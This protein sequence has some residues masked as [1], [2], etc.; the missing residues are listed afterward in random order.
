MQDQGWN[1]NDFPNII[2]NFSREDE[3]LLRVFTIDAGTY[4]RHRN[5]YRQRFSPLSLKNRTET[6][7]ERINLIEDRQR[8]RRLLRVYSL[9]MDS[10]ISKYRHFVKESQEREKRR[11]LA[12]V[13]HEKYLE[14]A[15]W[16]LLYF[17]KNWCE[18]YIDG[19]TTRKSSKISFRLKLL[20]SIVDYGNDFLPFQ[21][22]FDR[23][24][25]PYNK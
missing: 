1:I 11:Q 9:L 4:I 2:R 17:N 22:Q 15:L 16:P 10:D 14:C 20:S 25:C 12:Y 3:L 21:Y 19:V 24:I 6:V 18:S 5:R 8:K 7:L 23:R 13:Y